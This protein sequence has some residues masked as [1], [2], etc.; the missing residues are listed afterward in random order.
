[1]DNKI[2]KIQ[3]EISRLEQFDYSIFDNEDKGFVVDGLLG[4]YKAAIHKMHYTFIKQI[5]LGIFAGIIIAI[6]YAACIKGV[7]GLGDPKLGWARNLIMGALFPGCI[8][9]ITFLGGGIYTSH[10]VATIPALKRCVKS[11][12]YLKGVFGIFLGNAIGTFI[13]ALL[14]MAMG[15]FT[16]ENPTDL[17]TFWAVGVHKLMI[18][19]DAGKG[20]EGG[21][22]NVSFGTY[23]LGFLAALSAGILCNF[24]VSATL[25]MT[26]ST[27]QVTAAII[28]IFFAIAFFVIS[29]F[30]HCVAN[31]LFFWVMILEPLVNHN[32]DSIV[33]VQ[34]YAVMFLL[35]NI[36]P[37]MIGN[38]IGG[39]FMMPGILSLIYPNYTKAFF[40]YER[41][42]L[43]R[44]D[45]DKLNAKKETSD[46]KT[47]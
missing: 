4:G 10:V 45:L 43:L 41:L 8:F 24:L 16:N 29:G 40:K 31:T 27:K 20:L 35:F 11:R 2:I 5:L 44:E 25:P 36:L 26:F 15:M 22:K 42:Q 9:L 14:L 3:E 38:T 21:F 34:W 32:L 12:D 33:D 47:K 6:G 28:V 23:A 7:A 1:M 46:K 39:A 30:Q 37:A 17:A 19:S 13:T 18:I